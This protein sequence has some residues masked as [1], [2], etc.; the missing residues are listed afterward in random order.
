MIRIIPFLWLTGFGF[1]ENYISFIQKY[2]FK[3]FLALKIGEMLQ[4]FHFLNFLKF[5]KFL[6]FL[7]F[8]TFFS[9]FSKGEPWEIEWRTPRSD[10]KGAV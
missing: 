2:L 10:S 3:A 1:K 9:N 7:R 8:L 5:L 6:K 4:N